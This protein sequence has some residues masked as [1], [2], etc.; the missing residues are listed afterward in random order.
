MLTVEGLLGRQRARGHQA[1]H[2]IRNGVIDIGNWTSRSAPAWHRDA[3]VRP[4]A[5]PRLLRPRF[6]P[7]QPAGPGNRRRTGR[8]LNRATGRTCGGWSMGWESWCPIRVRLEQN[9]Q[10]KNGAAGGDRTHDPWLRRPILY[11]LSYSRTSLALHQRLRLWPIRRSLPVA[12][13]ILA[14]A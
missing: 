14:A 6:E 10:E 12:Q 9:R 7:A 4:D 13:P 3:G 5:A 1:F 2:L 8:T 11:P